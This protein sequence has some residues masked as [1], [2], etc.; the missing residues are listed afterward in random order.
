MQRMLDTLVRW[1]R[2]WVVEQPIA[3]AE[4]EQWREERAEET[5]RLHAAIA[6][7]PAPRVKQ[8]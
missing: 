6:A 5:A 4:Y 2:W 8:G 1:Y 7:V 3:A